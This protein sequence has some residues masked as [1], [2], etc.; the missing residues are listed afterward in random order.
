M[1]PKIDLSNM[2]EMM[3]V[4]V[5]DSTNDIAG[6]DCM[7]NSLDEM[8]KKMGERCVDIS[9]HRLDGKM[10]WVICRT[11]DREEKKGKISAL[12]PN[13]KPSHYGTIIIVGYSMGELGRP[14]MRS[15]TEADMKNINKH[16]GL[17]KVGNEYNSYCLFDLEDV[18]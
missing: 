18:S 7:C 8:Y 14:M 17:V 12:L 4:Y 6:E 16:M 11:N 3:T 9:S 10:I 15:L 2:G 5:I 1:I 13:D